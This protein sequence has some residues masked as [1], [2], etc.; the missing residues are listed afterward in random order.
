MDGGVGGGLPVNN[1]Q[2]S[3]L[4]NNRV[5]GEFIRNQRK[6]SEHKYVSIGEIQISREE[7]YQKTPLSGG[8]EEVEM[9]PTELLYQGMLPSLP[10]Y[11]I[12]LLKI[13]L[14]AAPTSKAKTDS[15]NIL[16]DVLPEEMPT[17]VL[18]SMKL[19]VDV[20]RHKE[21]IVKAISTI[22]LLLLKHFKLNHV[23]QDF[24]IPGVSIGND[25][26]V[27]P[28]NSSSHFVHLPDSSGLAWAGSVASP[29]TWPPLSAMRLLLSEEGQSCIEQCQDHNLV[30]EPTFFHFINN[31]EAF[32]HILREQTG[33]LPPEGA[34]AVQLRRV[35]QQIPETVP[36]QRL[37]QGPGGALQGLLMMEPLRA[38]QPCDTGLLD[39]S[40]P[41]RAGQPC[42][43]GLLDSSEPLRAGQPCDTGLLDSS[44][45]LRAG[46][47]CDTGLLDSSEP[48]RAGQPCD[49]GLLDSSEPLRAGQPCDTG[50][51]DSSEPLRAG[52]P[53][54]TGLLDSS[55]PLRA[56]QPCDTGLLDSSE[57][58]RAGQPCDTGLLDSS[59]P[60]RAGQPCDTGLLDS[61]EP[62]RAGQ[63]CDTGL[64]D[65]S[66]PLRAGQPCDTGLLDSSEPLRAGQPCD[67]GLLDSS[68]PLRA[69]QPCDTGLLDSSEP[70]RAGQPC[71][72]G[73]LDSSEPLRAGQPCDT[74]LLD[75]SEPLSAG[76]SVHM[77][78]S[79]KL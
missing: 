8:E 18:Q 77:G 69:G 35:P 5:R 79:L 3:M 47:P 19:G 56:G 52:Q 13:L 78:S 12:A 6:D 43:T 15:I 45:P 21:I 44:E 10:Q 9:S 34:F 29:S 64:L 72:T 59:E 20:N 32:T 76:G 61:S 36:L 17:T 54:D 62:L 49:T 23:Y 27:W 40:E 42:D 26:K 65:S 31:K 38:G 60:L 37:P 33:L 14:A 30:C 22:L 1:K 55:E 24:C 2:R 25:S 46:Q 71:D 16:A 48:L 50:L 7:E 63:P 67:T 11:M 70:L 73:L 58:L 4:S 57:P 39:S 66:E 41:L 28:G 53:C 51:L 68:E 74:G 75:S